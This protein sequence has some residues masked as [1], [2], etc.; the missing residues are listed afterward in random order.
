LSWHNTRGLLGCAYTCCNI[1]KRQDAILF[2]PLAE[3]PLGG[4]F[5]IT[6]VPRMMEQTPA[7]A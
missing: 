5:E 3:P 6:I 4:A 2:S 7:L 1:G